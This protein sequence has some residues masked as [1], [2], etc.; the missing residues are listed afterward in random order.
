MPRDVRRKQRIAE[1]VAELAQRVAHRGLRDPHA[2]RG[3]ADA[4]FGD[5]RVERDEQVQVGGRD[6]H[7]ANMAHQ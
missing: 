5:E 1:E 6:I 4:L 7:A 2:P 3:A